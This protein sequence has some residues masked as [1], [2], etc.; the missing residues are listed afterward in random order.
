MKNKLVDLNNHLFAELERLSDE[1][2]QGEELTAEINRAKAIT[3][4]ASQIIANGTLALKAKVIADNS[5]SKA[6]F[7][8]IPSRSAM[9]ESTRTAMSR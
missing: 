4:V 2:L 5:L 1:D 7:R 6:T 9:R 8:T 3:G